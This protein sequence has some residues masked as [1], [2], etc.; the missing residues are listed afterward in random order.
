MEKLDHCIQGQG[1]SE[2]SEYQW[3]CIQ[4]IFIC[5]LQGQGHS[6][7]LHVK[8]DPFYY[9]FWSADS[10]ESKLGLVIHHHKPECLVKKKRG[11]SSNVKV[12]VKG[13]NVNVCPD[14]IF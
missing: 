10:S 7:G 11:T 1:H 6:E 2:G 3:L 8:N 4:M 5:Y 12:I 9:I 14:D 13:K